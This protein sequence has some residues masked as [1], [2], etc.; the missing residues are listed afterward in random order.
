MVDRK[1]VAA[2]YGLMSLFNRYADEA[3][4]Y[5]YDVKLKESD[6]A[7]SGR[8]KL[9]CGKA[10]ITS[11][12]TGE[13]AVLTFGAI[14]IGDH[15][16]NCGVREYT[17]DED[18]ATLKADMLDPFNRADFHEVIRVLDR[19]FGESTYSL[20]SIFHDDQRRILNLVLQSTIAEAEAA[21]RQIY[22]THAPMMRFVSDLRVPLPRAFS[23]GAEFA[24]NS[25]LR[26]AFEN[27]DVDRI[28]TL[29]EEARSQGVSLDHA[30][31]AF[32]LRKT[33]KRLSDEF[34]ENPDDIELMKQFKAAAG[35]ARSLPFEV[36]VW[37]AQ[38]NYYAL[39]QNVFPARREAGDHEW[40]EHFIALG[41]NLAVK[42][43]EAAMELSKA[44]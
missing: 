1:K 24:L 6:R 21:Y 15:L 33:I 43:N 20:R 42:V 12:I 25:N 35:L 44:S 38:N 37:R 3:K 41:Q 19:H 14:H 32:A 18:Y 40:V 9:I 11:E 30:T 31:L 8:S 16:M 13:S 26:S 23:V 5:C 22:E 34:L 17:T 36:N 39:L 28:G 7:D 4:V 29:L 10:K 2:H 27:L